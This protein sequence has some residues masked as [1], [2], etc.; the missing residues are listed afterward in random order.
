MI[1]KNC[2]QKIIAIEKML[3]LYKKFKLSLFGKVNVKTLALS[4]LVYLFVVLLNPDNSTLVKN[5]KKPI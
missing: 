4:K 5:F 2:D 1:A 3:N